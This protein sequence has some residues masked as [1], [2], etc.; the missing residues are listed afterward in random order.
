MDALKRFSINGAGN[1]TAHEVVEKTGVSMARVQ[2]VGENT[3]IVKGY[4][5]K[6]TQRKKYF[7]YKDGVEIAGGYE[8]AEQIAHAL[9]YCLSAFGYQRRCAKYPNFTVERKWVDV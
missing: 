3:K 6:I 2:S 5:L 4:A 8:K 1:F 9:G 7:A